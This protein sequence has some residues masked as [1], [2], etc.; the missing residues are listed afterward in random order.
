MIV[1]DDIICL[2]RPN[3]ISINNIYVWQGYHSFYQILP[4]M[5]V[6]SYSQFYISLREK[7]SPRIFIF[8]LVPLQVQ[9]CVCCTAI[10]EHLLMGVFKLVKINLTIG[11]YLPPPSWRVFS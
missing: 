2:E 11:F 10:G 3:S 1:Y 9:Y 5:V 4:A 6:S 7:I 8:L